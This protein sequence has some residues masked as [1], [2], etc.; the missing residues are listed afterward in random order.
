MVES[1]SRSEPEFPF[2]PG[3]HPK[4]GVPSSGAKSVMKTMRQNLWSFRAFGLFRGSLPFL[5][6]KVKRDEFHAN[7]QAQVPEK[8]AL[9]GFN[10]KLFIFSTLPFPEGRVP[11]V[12][13]PSH[14]TR[15][16]P[17]SSAL[18]RKTKFFHR[19]HPA[20][21]ASRSASENTLGLQKNTLDPR[22]HSSRSCLPGSPR[23][24]VA[25]SR[26]ISLST[27]VAEITNSNL[28][29]SKPVH[30]TTHSVYKKT[31]LASIRVLFGPSPEIPFRPVALSPVRLTSSLYLKLANRPNPI[32]P[33]MRFATMLR[34]S[35]ILFLLLAFAML[36]PA[37][38]H[39]GS[40]NVFYQ[41]EAGP[42]QVL[43]SIQ[44]PEVVPGRAQINVRLLNG[45]A[46]KV[47]ALPVRWDA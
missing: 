5:F 41:G 28:Q 6:R 34:T 25:R 43:I 30:R 16:V 35:P 27:Q 42:H 39:V 2:I 8:S 24:Y 3:N 45:A 31:H 21:G 17:Q 11:R 26:A 7:F 4:R 38:A 1:N 37:E 9:V 18:Y 14:R 22:K 46:T 40:P 47:T 44:P 19:R 33:L 10:R 15:I 32:H 13:K 23:C 12:P 36:L 29:P 20:S